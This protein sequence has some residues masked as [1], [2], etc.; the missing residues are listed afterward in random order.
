M[1]KKSKVLNCLMVCILT[2][3]NLLPGNPLRY[4]LYIINVLI[5]ILALIFIANNIDK[6]QHLCI[7]KID[8]L[9]VLLSF[10]TLIPLF[11]NKYLSLID[12]IE[13]ILRYISA[14]N[15]YFIIK[16]YIKDNDNNINIVIK[17]F[18]YMSIVLV[19]IGIDMM[20]SNYL[21]F[22]YNF[23]RTPI[24][25]KESPERMMSLFKY[26]NVFC[27]Y[28]SSILFLTLGNYI[29]EQNKI[30]KMTY[31]TFLFIQFFG[32]IMSYSRLCWFIT[33][34]LL[35][36]Y[37]IILKNEKR[38]LIKALILSS[39]SAFIYYCIY[40]YFINKSNTIV[41]CFILLIVAILQLLLYFSIEKLKLKKINKKIVIIV[42]II[43]L[44]GIILM[45]VLYAN[46]PDHLEL[47]NNNNYKRNYRRQNIKVEKNENYKF[48]FDVEAISNIENNFTIA[49]KQLDEE[50][51]EIK[52]DKLVFDNYKGIK[53]LD[54]TTIDNTE[55][56]TVS[57]SSQETNNKSKLVIYSAKLNEQNI[58]IYYKLIPISF[59]NRIEKFKI[60]TASTNLRIIYMKKAIDIIKTSPIFGLGGNA[61]NHSNMDGIKIKTIAE[62]S[63]PLQLFL[64]NGVFSFLIYVILVIKLIDVSFRAIKKQKNN[65]I[66]I[67]IIIG[68]FTLIL[69]SIADFDFHFQLILFEMY[70][71]IA[72]INSIMFKDN[73]IY[74]KKIYKYIY[75][76]FLVLLLYINIG[77]TITLQ[78]NYRE[79]K[80]KTEYEQLQE[81]NLKIIL[82][83]YYYKN[84]EEKMNSLS[85]IKNKGLT[86]PNNNIES[87]II[88][89][90]RFI[91]D[92]E[93]N[94]STN[95]YNTIIL[96]TIDM[97]NE[98][99]Q[100][101]ILEKVNN[102]WI[103]EVGA[104]NKTIYN[105][106]KNRL[107]L[108][109]DNEKTRI[110]I[111][112]LK[113]LDNV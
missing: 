57:I 45:S 34:V 23:L 83:P 8:I 110:Y 60:K 87:E 90:A 79:D 67:S 94:K 86:Y 62:H 7:N 32:I 97:M 91:T 47:F 99:N 50:E 40:T 29:K 30:K 27:I 56:I 58:K 64:Q 88:K 38:Q 85:S 43:T 22:L 33:I 112:N 49:I 63:Y 54:I 37:F 25:L 102:I 109:L 82:S 18:I 111:D 9:I 41:L 12:T 98:E 89:C 28:I 93:K 52:I 5:N 2:I 103:N 104:N 21:D 11:F 77:E 48:K 68:L 75:T 69:H 66:L 44:V 26:P 113:M 105:A 1:F 61:W 81:A 55:S 24:L 16:I 46:Q 95:I 70:I 100:D 36:I 71:F 15:I 13:D 31:L 3:I 80:N 92:I 76:V 96:N 106:M 78:M 65:I 42:S 19:L 17:A 84:Y 73:K 20:S 74:V 6:K 59:V 39:V 53:E 35:I 101:E 4:N 51:K 108:V 10:S 14:L 72:I 107:K